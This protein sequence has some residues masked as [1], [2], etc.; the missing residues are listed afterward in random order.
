VEQLRE[1][2]AC[3][4]H[5]G[6]RARGMLQLIAPRT[7]PAEIEIASLVLTEIVSNAVRHGCKGPDGEITVAVSRDVGRLRIEV[8]QPGVLFDLDEVRR[9]RPGKERGWGVLLLDR[10]TLS[11]GVGASEVWAE[12]ALTN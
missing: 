7:S 3:G 4:Q 1:V 12:I 8:A 2:F 5:A 9:R 10:L 6:R 11:W